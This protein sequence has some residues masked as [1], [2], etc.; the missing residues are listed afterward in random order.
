MT[1]KPFPTL[2]DSIALVQDALPCLGGAERVLE[3]VT[4]LFPAAPIHT[5]VFRPEAFAGTRLA[6]HPVHTSFLDRLPGVRRNHRLFLPLFPLAIEAFDL[7]DYDLVISFNYAV[8][9]GVVTRPDQLH[10][11]YTYTPLRQAWHYHHEYLRTLSPPARWLARPLLHYLRL[12]DRAAADRVDR[13]VAISRWVSDCIWRAYR[14]TSVVVHPPVDIDA[15]EP[16]A[17][18]GDHYV[19]VARL[20]PHKRVDL[21]V[22]AFGRLGRP[23]LV[24]GEGSE[25][26]RLEERAA[27]NVTFLGRVPD[28]ELADLLARARGLVHAAEEDFGIALV[29][30]QAAGCPVVAYGRG[31][32]S[33][34]V[35]DGRTGVLFQRQTVAAVQEAVSILEG[36]SGLSTHQLRASAER[37]SRERFEL[38]LGQVLEQEWER[39]QGRRSGTGA[40]TSQERQAAHH[41]TG[42]PHAV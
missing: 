38:R 34:I 23:L 26:A 21:V 22:D 11:S 14:R 20:E 2:P 15:F 1:G 19:T 29:E 13:F 9:H 10:V 28:G 40:R 35:L 8:A 37:F 16:H 33:E 36:L 5:L 12:W 41:A 6:H 39:F 32:A 7:T 17:V 30:A 42:D 18:R 4:A 24:V 3:V 27:A 31:G 25:R